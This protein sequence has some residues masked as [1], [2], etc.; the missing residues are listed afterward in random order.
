MN[1][2][3]LDTAMKYDF[4]STQPS[5]AATSATANVTSSDNH[6]S[7]LDFNNLL[8][9]KNG[10]TGLASHRTS[11]YMDENTLEGFVQNLNSLHISSNATTATAAA[12]A[13]EQSS[14]INGNSSGIGHTV[15][16]SANTNGWW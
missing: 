10:P 3:E 7:I 2:G 14:Q 12:K 4:E 1:L 11:P 16:T 13:G 15:T 5:Q 9:N 6:N 8:S